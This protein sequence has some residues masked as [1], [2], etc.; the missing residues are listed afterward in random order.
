MNVLVVGG[1]SGIGLSIVLNLIGKS[2]V[3]KVFVI[4]KVDYPND[5]ADEKVVFFQSD[6][7]K[8]DFSVFRSLNNIQALFI[9]AGFGHLKYFQ[10]LS[11]DY[12]QDS[13][14]VNAVA[15]IQIIRHY[16]DR[17]LSKDHFYCAVMVSIAARLSS[18][19]FSVYSAT[20]AALSKFIEA[21]N[22]ELD[23]QGSENRILE[24]SPG[25]LKGT[26]FTGST[27]QPELTASLAKEIIERSKKKEELFIPQYDEVFKGVLERYHGD[28]HKY[29]IES[30]WYK[31]RLGRV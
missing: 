25:S 22:V 13:F 21:V 9:T 24:V 19:L 18:P 2:E 16:Y 10:D 15:P 1:S 23:V 3:D 7:S 4:D 27:S 26:G 29:G 31:K 8:G 5:Y 17:I 28:P 20:K 12:I 14:A 11:E 6:L 30:Y